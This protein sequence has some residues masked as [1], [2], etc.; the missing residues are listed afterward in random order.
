MLK[1]SN[2]LEVSG[3]HRPMTAQVR[4]Q[5]VPHSKPSFGNQQQ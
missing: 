4:Q 2:S 1:H 5:D 3:G